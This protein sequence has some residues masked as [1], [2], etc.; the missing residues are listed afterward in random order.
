VHFLTVWATD[1]QAQVNQ[2][3]LKLN[4]QAR[5]KRKRNPKVKRNLN[6]LLDN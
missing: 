5:L 6:P 4:N 1:K 3:L 2:L